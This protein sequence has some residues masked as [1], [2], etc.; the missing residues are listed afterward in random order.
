MS[1]LAD[2]LHAGAPDPAH[3]AAVNILLALGE[4]VER[5]DF[6]GAYVYEDYGDRAIV[7]WSAIGRDL[8]D[9]CMLPVSSGERAALRIA[10]GI[11]ATADDLAHL[12]A[13]LR[14]VA[15]RAL[16]A[17]AG[18]REWAHD[19]RSPNG[20]IPVPKGVEGISVGGHHA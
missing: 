2:R 7:N 9:W 3:H 8:A 6:Q 16:A 1:T 10:A 20:T 15:E 13:E 11:V 12:D 4:L 19:Y 14:L 5:P 17:V 18:T